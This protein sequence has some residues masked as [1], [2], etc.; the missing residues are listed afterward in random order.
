M[1]L[2]DDNDRETH[3]KK[4]IEMLEAL[5]KALPRI[6]STMVTNTKRVF[7]RRGQVKSYT[8]TMWVDCMIADIHPDE[9][10]HALHATLA[11]AFE[12][13][14]SAFTIETEISSD[15]QDLDKLKINITFTPPLT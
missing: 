1:P 5:N 14:A 11:Q 9:F 8:A 3:R 4:R 13:P 10:N 2:I 7:H 6:A 15:I 12:L